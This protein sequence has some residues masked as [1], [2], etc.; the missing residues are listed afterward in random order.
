MERSNLLLLFWVF[1]AWS[2]GSALA[3]LTTGIDAPTYI[4]FPL[5]T[6]AYGLLWLASW[7]KVSIRR[8]EGE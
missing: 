2:A 5:G 4:V 3:K 6:A 1:F 8:N 7:V